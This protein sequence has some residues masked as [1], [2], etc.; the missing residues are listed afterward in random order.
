MRKLW[1]REYILR[2]SDFDKYDKIKPSAV[3]DLFQ[4]AAGQHAEEIG[5]GFAD[6]I[7][8]GYMWVLVRTKFEIINA[9]TRY[10]KV[11]INTWPLPPNRI[12]YKREY[13]IKDQ[14]GNLLIKGSSEWVVIDSV[15][16]RFLSVPDLYPF[17]DGFHEEVMFEDKLQKIRDFEIDC[18]C[19]TVNAGF[20]DLDVN[21]H[22]NNTKYANYA[23]DAINPSADD[24]IRCFQIDYRKEVMQGTQLNVYYLREDGL[25]TV[26][27]LNNDGDIMFACKID[28]K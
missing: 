14:G 26:K 27:G 10:Q 24:T 4:D 15:K 1:Q 20:S 3:L 18:D 19:H 9:P 22:V 25:I 13:S 7:K 28:F 5:V 8:H 21:G 11:V 17:K 16:R 23:I 6:L 12:N 2:A